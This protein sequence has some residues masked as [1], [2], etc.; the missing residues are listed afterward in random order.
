M[1]VFKRIKC[2]SSK[3][4]T[5]AVLVFTMYRYFLILLAV[6][7]TSTGVAQEIRGLGE[8]PRDSSNTK[9]EKETPK[10]DK[11]KIIS[12][13]GDTTYVD[14]TL[15]IQKDYSLNYLRKDDFGLLP[16]SNIGQPYTKLTEDFNGLQIMPEFG[17]RAAHFAYLE[18]DDIYYY[19][20]P[21]PYTDLMFR[22]TF[23]QGQLLDAFFTSNIS[24]QI[25]F[26]VAHKGMHSQG[27]YQ[28]IR[29]KQSSFR[30][31]LSY[32]TKNERYFLNAHFIG[33]RL[34]GEQNGGLTARSNEQFGS[35]DKEFKDRGVLD[36]NYED[37]ERNLRVKRF[38]LQHHY[39]LIQ[40][41]S[42]AN[43]QVQLEHVFNFT[44]KEYYYDQGAPSELYGTSLSNAD[45][46]DLTEFQELSHQFSANYQ[47]N[48]LGKVSFSA[49]HTHYNYGYKRALYLSSGDIPNRLKGDV[50]SLGATYQKEIGGFQLSGEGMINT[51]GNMDGNYLHAKAAYELDDENK[52]EAGI[53]TNSYR[54]N[55]NFLLYQS[56][57]KNYNWRHDFANIQKQT[58][59]FK[60]DSRRLAR[61]EL[62][63]TRLHNYAYFAMEKPE[64]N[65]MGADTV[66][67]PKQ[68]GGDVHYFKV[69]ADREFKFG[70]FALDN[71]VLYQKVIKGEE[72]FHVPDLVIR[73]S[74]YY[75]GYLFHR[76]LYMQTGFTHNYFTSYY[77][78]GYDPVMNEYYVQDREKLKGFSRLDFFLNAKVQT[79]RIFFKL[80][81]ITTLID[82][83]GHYA[84]S[85]EP[86]RDWV[87]R[88]GMI[89][90]F[91]W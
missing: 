32:H 4:D 46:K 11:Y 7:L 42:T 56:D 29:A 62:D 80:E 37:A 23:E 54:P 13:T 17:A 70:K 36:V 43:N 44:D 50:V 9:A 16:F 66:M 1:E 71:S 59:H 77:A 45:I 57:Y 18:V 85:H 15:T 67:T 48:L 28:H 52:V 64:Q 24:S 25:N 79:A 89:W 83:N 63:Y 74:L 27:K 68:Y 55:Y 61:V 14:T 78:D 31:T 8:S 12:V 19:E 39:N 10:I 53:A 90:D 88:F 35:K 49:R 40:G 38:Y 26:S 87:I 22:T 75:S 73:N 91:F 72:V 60:L 81:N 3:N 21:T 65:N 51:V 2:Y 76:N 84:A 33:Q 30:A 58:L 86:Y 34:P 6:L 20:V 41:D 47:N 69:R 82:N 5:F